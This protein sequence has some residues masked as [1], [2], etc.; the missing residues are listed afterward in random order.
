[1]VKLGEYQSSSWTWRVTRPWRNAF[2]YWTRVGLP[3][4]TD[5][6]SGPITI[7]TWPQYA[8]KSSQG[9][10]TTTA[11]IHGYAYIPPEFPTSTLQQQN[12]WFHLDV[13]ESLQILAF[14]P[15]HMRNT[16]DL[17]PSNFTDSFFGHS[18]AGAAVKSPDAIS[19]E[20][21]LTGRYGH[22]TLQTSFDPLVSFSTNGVPYFAVLRKDSSLFAHHFADR[23]KFVDGLLGDIHF[24]RAGWQDFPPGRVSHADQRRRVDHHHRHRR[25]SPRSWNLEFSPR[26]NQHFHRTLQACGVYASAFRYLEKGAS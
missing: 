5:F 2:A 13:H 24:D 17:P 21:N 9:T 18:V 23:I 3:D 14:L 12:D 7:R 8:V 10:M 22:F 19:P 11:D 4:D 20:G 6:L 26:H 15:A 16:S 1:M 25:R